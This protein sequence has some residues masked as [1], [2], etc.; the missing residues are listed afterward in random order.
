M[1]FN[2]EILLHFVAVKCRILPSFLW[3]ASLENPAGELCIQ[4]RPIGEGW[5]SAVPRLEHFNGVFIKLIS[6]I[7]I[8]W[9][10]CKYVSFILYEIRLHEWQLEQ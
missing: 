9:A 6:E 7:V 1:P 4:V 8:S 10:D 5:Q 2:Q 3:E